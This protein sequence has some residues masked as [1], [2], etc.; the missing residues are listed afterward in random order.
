MHMHKKPANN[1]PYEKCSI[2]M[3][4][5]IVRHLIG[6]FLYNEYACTYM[7]MQIHLN[8][9]LKLRRPSSGALFLSIDRRS[10]AKVQPP[11][12]RPRLFAISG[13]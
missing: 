10:I 13:R 4:S 3:A 5:L 8:M 7:V 12:A 1:E 6:Q 2:N 9:P 11:K